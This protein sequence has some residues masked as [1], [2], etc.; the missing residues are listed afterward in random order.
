MILW[1]RLVGFECLRLAIAVIGNSYQG[2]VTWR[3]VRKSLNIFDFTN[4]TLDR[5]LFC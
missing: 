4:I 5:W 2:P 3:L 1:A